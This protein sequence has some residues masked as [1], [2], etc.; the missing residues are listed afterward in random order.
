[1]F[2]SA[3]NGEERG[4]DSQPPPLE[5]GSQSQSLFASNDGVVVEEERFHVVL[6]SGKSAT[7]SVTT[8]IT[9][10]HDVTFSDGAEER[11]RHFRAEVEEKVMRMTE[12]QREEQ[13]YDC[14]EE[15]QHTYN[16]HYRDP[17]LLSSAAGA[18]AAAE[19]AAAAAAASPSRATLL[20]ELDEFN[21]HIEQS[22]KG[23]SRFM[24]CNCKFR[25]L[26]RDL[27]PES[28]GRHTFQHHI[29]RLQ[30]QRIREL[31]GMRGD[32]V[33]GAPSAASTASKAASKRAKIEPRRQ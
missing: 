27:F 8:V 11:A 1:M 29:N 31:H 6:P 30:E 7:E 15:A 14:H 28:E 3:S 26:F 13:C 22:K 25:D 12:E 21:L 18:A 5:P 2:S 16:S 19:P 9:P 10:D 32:R 20:R 23:A 24:T 17:R 4:Y 33:R